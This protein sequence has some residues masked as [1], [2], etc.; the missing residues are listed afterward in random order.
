MA[1]S[2]PSAYGEK[3]VIFLGLREVLQRELATG[4]SLRALYVASG[5]SKAMSYPLFARYVTR[6]LPNESVIQ[7][8]SATR[9]ATVP[10]IPSDRPSSEAASAPAAS[11][12]P[13]N[14]GSKEHSDLTPKENSDGPKAPP[15]P[16]GFVRLGGLPD[17]NKDKLI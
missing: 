4:R 8:W 6:Y 17:D 12:L 14:S 2:A 5:A 10:T 16:R 11:P 13:N 3:R 7:R 1:K 9:S 15:R